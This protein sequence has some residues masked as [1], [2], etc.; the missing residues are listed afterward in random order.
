MLLCEK[1]L[2]L[3]FD[4]LLAMAKQYN[5]YS[6]NNQEAF[7]KLTGIEGTIPPQAVE[8]EQAVLGALM[9]ERDAI[10]DMA[11]NFNGPVRELMAKLH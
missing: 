7:E 6:K 2:N 9:L 3:C 4:K 11:I 10:I 8:L 1:Y 5:K